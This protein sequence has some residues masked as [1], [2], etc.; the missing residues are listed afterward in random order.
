[1]NEP[2]PIEYAAQQDVARFLKFLELWRRSGRAVTSAGELLDYAEQCGMDLGNAVTL[3][4]RQ[5]N[6]GRLLSSV[7]G[8]IFQ[9]DSWEYQIDFLSRT[10]RGKAAYVLAV[11]P[12]ESP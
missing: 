4:G 6:L 5:T 2:T 3:R 9:G 7:H 10:V 1:M 12:R 11:M 8:V